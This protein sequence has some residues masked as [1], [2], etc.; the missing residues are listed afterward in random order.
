MTNATR[1]RSVQQVCAWDWWRLQIWE[2]VKGF[3]EYDGLSTVVS[4]LATHP[5]LFTLFFQPYVNPASQSLVVGKSAPEHNVRDGRKVS[6]LLH[7]LMA[8]SMGP[9]SGEWFGGPAG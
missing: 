7:Y 5:E 2:Y 1:Q 3:M 4:A 9:G 8:T 6:E